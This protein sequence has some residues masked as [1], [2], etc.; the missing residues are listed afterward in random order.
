MRRAIVRASFEHKFARPT[1]WHGRMSFRR[2]S[3]FRGVGRFLAHGT[4]AG[5]ANFRLERPILEQPILGRRPSLEDQRQPPREASHLS[6]EGIF[7]LRLGKRGAALERGM[8][9]RVARSFPWMGEDW[10]SSAQRCS[11]WARTK[12]RQCGIP[13]GTMTSA[14]C[15]G[16]GQAIPPDR[17]R[18]NRAAGSTQFSGG[19]MQSGGRLCAT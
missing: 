13:S 5:G 3:R 6:L 2:R 7:L 14:P 18:T 19:E 1:I 4:S 8:S 15:S 11:A 12:W 16:N 10:P 17:R 9:R